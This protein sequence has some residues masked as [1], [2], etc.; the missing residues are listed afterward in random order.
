MI[1]FL[2]ILNV[3]SIIPAIWMWFPEKE[4][5]PKDFLEYWT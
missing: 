2:I 3:L 4:E 1:T 5:D